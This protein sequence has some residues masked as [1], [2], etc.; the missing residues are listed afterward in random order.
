LAGFGSWA[1]KIV[2][3]TGIA[4]FLIPLGIYAFLFAPSL[5]YRFMVF[6]LPFSATAVVNY[7]FTGSSTGLQATTFFGALWMVREGFK[8]IRKSRPWRS[9]RMQISMR[10]LRFFMFAV[11]VSLV[12]PIWIHGRLTV[13]CPDL[14]CTDS[15][16]LTFTL[17]HITQTMYLAYGVL[18]TI[19][20]AVKNSDLRQFRKSIQIFLAS[21]IFASCW[22]FLQWYC[23]RVGLPYPAFVFNN[24][25]SQSAMGYLQDIQE[26]GLTRISSVATEPS[27]L[28][29]YTLIAL[30]FAIF[31]LVGKYP[32]I[33]RFW[34]RTALVVTALLLLMTTSTT[35]YAGLAILL[36]VSLFGLWYLGRLGIIPV[37]LVAFSV[38]ALYVAYT[39]SDIIQALAEKMIFSKSEDY[40]GIGRINSLILSFTYF[41]MYPILGIGWGSSTSADVIL[42]LLSNTGILGLLAFGWFLR[43]LFSQLWQSMLRPTPRSGFSER[44]YWACALLVASFILVATSELSGFA[45]VYG[46]TWFVFGMA[47]AVPLLH[48]AGLKRHAHGELRTATT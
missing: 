24:N 40:S 28:A 3:V 5:L 25:A 9:Q 38:L 7:G 43:N 1:R 36:P 48:E 34:D 37:V 42:K 18:L 44:T 46:H 30:V 23:Y 16:P 19:F 21:A 39:S 10:R 14:G 32:V 35:A 4:A 41:R 29:Q 20:I 12:M 11:V 2:E 45:F 22:G 17:R 13:D 31:A 26:L 15:G 27:I 6:S 33:S 8:A 47:L